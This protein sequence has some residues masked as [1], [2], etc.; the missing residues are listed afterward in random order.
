MG[1]HVRY[2]HH[3][4][5]DDVVQDEGE[6][7]L[8]IVIQQGVNSLFQTHQPILLLQRGRGRGRRGEMKKWTNYISFS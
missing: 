5:R 4:L 1:T 2:V 6:G 8:V 7:H 3:L